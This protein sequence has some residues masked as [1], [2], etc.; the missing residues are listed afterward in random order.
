[1]IEF[2]RTPAIAKWLGPS[3]VNFF[4]RP[5]AGKDIHAER[6]AGRLDG[7]Y[8]SS[9]ELLKASDDIDP[10]ELARINDGHLA[11]SETF[12]A[13]IFPILSS[14]EFQGRPLLLSAV[15]RKHGEEEPVL[16]TLEKAGHPLRAVVN[17]MIN[18]EIVWQRFDK[19]E[20]LENRGNRVDD[21][22]EAISHRLNVF[23]E[24]TVRVIDL[25]RDLGYIIDVDADQTK[26]E[27]ERDVLEGLMSRIW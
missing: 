12:F 13:T 14:P 24:D 18:E 6:L 15:G 3:T 5:F 20:N 26:D 7:T 10:V 23:N 2:E 1:M 9:G 17:L 8:L 21:R 25:Y 16:R 22:R 27:V 4:G 11:E 19:K